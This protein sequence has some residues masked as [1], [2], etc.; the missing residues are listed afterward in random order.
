LG[1]GGE[2]GPAI[3]RYKDFEK[4]WA[5]FLRGFR[6]L[7]V[8]IGPVAWPPVVAMRRDGTPDKPEFSA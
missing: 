2:F 6:R 4:I 8:V 7:R 5:Y 1:S 3:K